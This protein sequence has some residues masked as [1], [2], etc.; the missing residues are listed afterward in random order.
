MTKT[1][2]LTTTIFCLSFFL[3]AK[4]KMKYV[5]RK[6]VTTIG[7]SKFNFKYHKKN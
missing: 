6:T 7:L 3:F 1:F 5:N 4:K 2:I